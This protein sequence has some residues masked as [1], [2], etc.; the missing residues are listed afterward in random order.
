MNTKKAG[1][2]NKNHLS[3][4]CKALIVKRKLNSKNNNIITNNENLQS[5]KIKF[6]IFKK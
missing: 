1:V 4:N 2:L 3:K 5:K 6:I